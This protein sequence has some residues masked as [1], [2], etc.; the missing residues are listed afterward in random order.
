MA[1]VNQIFILHFILLPLSSFPLSLSSSLSLSFCLSLFCSIYSTSLSYPSH[2]FLSISFLAFLP[3]LPY[4]PPPLTLSVLPFFSSH[5]HTPFS[6]PLSL[7]PY[8]YTCMCLCDSSALVLS[9]VRVH[10]VALF[11]MLVGKLCVVTATQA[12]SQ[13]TL[14]L[15]QQGQHTCN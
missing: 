15:C 10:V 9:V 3:S 6:P 7:S 12:S 11:S 8:M 13:V 14:T 2:S 4:S 1:S 5:L